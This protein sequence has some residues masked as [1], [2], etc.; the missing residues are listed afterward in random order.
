MQP[1]EEANPA[2]RVLDR[3]DLAV[4]LQES[5]DF[6]AAFQRDRV[7]FRARRANRAQDLLKVGGRE[8]CKGGPELLGRDARQKGLGQVAC[9][10]RFRHS[11]LT[12][13]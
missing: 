8:P 6:L 2:Q 1:E 5:L 7:R 13:D 3:I 4:I 11:V 9:R 12:H 10:G